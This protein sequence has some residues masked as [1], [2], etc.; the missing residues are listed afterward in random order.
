[1]LT[2]TI[3]LFFGIVLLSV[4]PFLFGRAGVWLVVGV[5]A[6]MICVEP[7]LYSFSEKFWAE[8]KRESDRETLE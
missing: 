5:A 2:L 8:E 1:M 7:A 4:L 3:S 6:L